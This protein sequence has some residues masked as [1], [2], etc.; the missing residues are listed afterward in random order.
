MRHP[1][2]TKSKERRTEMKWSGNITLEM[3]GNED[4][5]S[6][7]SISVHRGNNSPIVT[8]KARVLLKDFSKIGQLYPASPG[9]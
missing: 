1:E 8:R 5:Y 9:G 4:T 2:G 3:D 7:G 6:P